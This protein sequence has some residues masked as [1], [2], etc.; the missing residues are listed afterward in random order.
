MEAADEGPA[1]QTL[2][3]INVAVAASNPQRLYATL[4]TKT[5][6]GYASGRGLGVY[7]SDDAGASW[8]KITDDPRPA[9]KIGGGDLSVPVVDPKDPDIVYV[10]SIVTCRST[11]GGKTW[12]SL[13]GAPGGDDYQNMWIN[14]K[15]PQDPAAGKRSGC[16]R[17]RERWRKLGFLV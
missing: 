6:G 17:H 10:T 9:M 13:R 12:I 14:P 7:R 3:Q 2:V 1:R 16:G 5:E 4:P 11:D 15:N 8:Q